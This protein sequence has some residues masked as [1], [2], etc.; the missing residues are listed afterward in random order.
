MKRTMQTALFVSMGMALLSAVPADTGAVGELVEETWESAQVEGAKVGSLH[1]TVCRIDSDN[2]K[3]LRAAAELELTFKRNNA[4]LRLR[5]VHGTEETK[6]G[7][8]IGVFMRQGQDGE[9]QLVLAGSL[10]EGRMHVRIDNGRIDRRLPWS[11]DVVGLYRL[12]HLFQERKPKPDERWTI[13]RYDPT[14][15][16]VVTIRVAVKER[17][18]ISRF[19]QNEKSK[20]LRVE[21]TPEPLE[22]P[23]IKVQ[24]PPEVWWLDE[25]FVPVRRQFELEG[26]GTVVLTR[27][28]Q[29]AAKAAGTP[30]QLTDIGLKT[31]IPLNRALTRPYSMRSA[32]YRITLRGDGDPGSAVARDDHQEISALHGDTFELHVHPLTSR[33][34]E[35]RTADPSL[36]LPAR[37]SEECLKTC[38]FI[39]CGDARVKELA[40]RAAG[41]EKDAWAKARRIERW[42]KQNMRVDNAAP[43]GPASDAARL[44]RGDCRHYALLTAALCRAEGIPA[45]TAIGLLYVEKARRP[46][47]GFHMWTELWIDGQWLGL[48]ATLGQGS[49]SAAHVKIN[50]HS[51]HDTQSLTP[52]LPASRILGK[53]T[54]AV[55]S[56]E[57]EP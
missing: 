54:I 25:H 26:L 23:G 53:I 40:K 34:R 21:L 45:R 16:A 29:E 41:G 30:R 43:L 1:T 22:A 42:V 36:T 52:L 10:E 27:T 49:V 7:K 57:S 13:K 47:M 33:K 56:S 19:A 8:V 46:M 37:Q 31:L 55:L 12:E 14:Y 4:L 44:L 24:P 5:R 50:D 6:D 38:Y 35:R 15:N 28:T 9:R 18:E 48:D 39:D 51:W 3:H 2:G 20:L 32:V 11:D 17:E